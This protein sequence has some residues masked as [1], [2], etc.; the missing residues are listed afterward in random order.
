LKNI[1]KEL[2]SNITILYVE[3]EDMIREEVTYFFSKYVKNFHT[4]K[5]GEEGLSLFKKI[6]PDII[7]T[8]IQMPKMN[9]LDMIKE[10]NRKN[11]P[12]IITTAYSDID[13][14]LRAIELNINKFIIKPIDLMELMR[15]IQ[16]CIY[17]GTMY[18]KFFEKENLLKIV[19]ENV[20][21]SITDKNGVIIDSSSAFCDFVKYSKAEL[22]G[23][24]HRILKHENTPD[25]FYQDMWNQISSGKKFNAEIRNKK[26]DG[27]IYWANLTITP[28]IKDGEVINYT[29]IRQDIT[30]KKKLELLAIEDTLTSIYNR[31]YFNKIIEKE[32]RRTKRENINIC[33]LSIDIDDFKKYNDTFG[34]PKGD[35]ILINVAQTLKISASRATDY[36]FRMGGEEFSIIFS[37]VNVEKA[38]EFSNELVKKIENLQIKHIEDRVVTISAGL[39]CMDANDI[40]DVEELYKYSDVAL[41][42]AKD[43]GKNQVVLFGNQNYS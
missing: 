30:N 33:L 16:E 15:S 19:D 27:E 14:F 8:D 35:E 40:E 13:Y 43:R 39:V 22:L 36:V 28:L 38:L 9:G 2:L 3:D 4:A 32:L 24:T 42:K 21:L 31:R 37:G 1:N 23:Q 6:N 41:Y 12:I 25:E 17:N 18:D 34:H 20:L 29:A 11:I 26:K 10:I 5:D 7:I